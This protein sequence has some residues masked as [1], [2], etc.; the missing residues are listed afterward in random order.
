MKKILLLEDE[1]DVLEANTRILK[2][3]GYEVL[4][5]KTVKEAYDILKKEVPDLLILDIILPDGSGYDVCKYFR[6]T[7]NNP[8]IFLSGKDGLT[9]KIE[10]LQNG[11]DYYLTKPYNIDEVLAVISRLL[12]KQNDNF[13]IVRGDLKID[14]FHKKAFVKDIDIHLTNKEYELLEYFVKHEDE[15]ISSDLLY[16]K[17]WHVKALDDTRT[18]RFHVSNLRKKIKVSDSRNYDIISLYGRGYKFT[19]KC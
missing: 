12:K 4:T 5:S 19:T 9:D 11:G 7:A 10:G 3:R 13:I 16:E 8:I 15:E 6:K 14:F 2:R 1:V 17:I 18:I